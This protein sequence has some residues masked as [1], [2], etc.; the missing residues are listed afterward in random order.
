[1]A[2][3][4]KRPN[5]SY[6]VWIIAHNTDVTTMEPI[7][8]RKDCDQPRNMKPRTTNSSMIGT[9][10]QPAIKKIKNPP[11]RSAL[12]YGLGEIS[13]A[14]TID[15]AK[16]FGEVSAGHSDRD[17]KHGD[18]KRACYNVGSAIRLNLSRRQCL[19]PI[20]H[21][22]HDGQ[23]KPRCQRINAVGDQADE[24]R[25]HEVPGP[26]RWWRDRD[27]RIDVSEIRHVGFLRQFRSE[28]GRIFLSNTRDDY[29]ASHMV[30]SVA[31]RLLK[32]CRTIVSQ[33]ELLR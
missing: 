7:G 30:C 18:R 2:K 12:A 8:P 33:I 3:I 1:V 16:I 25:L 24:R 17:P 5:Q 11:A 23:G 19:R 22:Q 28:S 6:W 13:S 26:E 32:P 15:R 29:P 9:A 20:V 14:P 10:I 4:Q 21:G 27:R 31:A